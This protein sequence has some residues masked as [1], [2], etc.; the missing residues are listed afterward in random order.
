M[1]RRYTLLALLTLLPC[2]AQRY[3]FKSYGE[4]QGLTNLA[5]QCF[6]QD[7]TGFI[8]VGTQNGLFRYDGSQFEPFGTREGLPSN[9][10]ESLHESPD[11]DLWIGT[12]AGLARRRNGRFERIAIIGAQGVYGRN[13]IASDGSGRLFIATE[14][15]LAS[16]QAAVD[17]HEPFRLIPSAG[18]PVS[19]VFVNRDG[20]VW[21]AWG[22][23]IFRFLNGTAS[24]F[25]SP[26][27]PDE[28]WDAILADG[29]GDLWVR[30][31]K[32]LAV[33]RKGSQRFSL[34]RS[35][36]LNGNGTYGTLSLDPEGRLLVPSYLGLVRQNGAGW[37]VIGAKQGLTIDEI[38]FAKFDRE[39]SIWIGMLG[40][41]LLRWLGYAQWES[42]GHSEGLRRDSTWSIARDGAGT[43]WVGTQLGLNYST[44][45]RITDAPGVSRWAYLPQFDS[46]LVRASARTR[47]GD[48]WIGGDPGPLCRIEQASKMARCYGAPSGVTTT[49]I[50]HLMVDRDN[51]VWLSSRDGLYVSVPI[52]GPLWR[53]GG[54]RFGRI[55]IPGTEGEEGFFASVQD[56]KG[57]IWAGS[58]R[59]LVRLSGGVWSR[60]T[61]KDGLLQ[62]A[63]GYLASAGAGV[64][65]GYRESLGIT[66]VTPDRGRIALAH[67]SK[68]NGLE[69]DKAIFLGDDKHGRIWYGSDRGVDVLDNGSWR[70][71]GKADG[72]IW[73]D[74]NS[75]AFFADDD[76][77]VWIGTS[78]GLSHYRPSQAHF[79]DTPPPIVLTSARLGGKDVDV[80]RR[81]VA[82]HRDNAFSVTFAAPAYQHETELK[83]RYRLIGVEEEWTETTHREQRYAGLHPGVY[84]FEVAARDG[85][86]WSK[87][88]AR[89]TFEIKPPWWL[90]WWTRLL[91]F[92]IALALAWVMWKR[93]MVRLLEERR[94]LE[95][96]VRERT[97]EL[98]QERARVLEEKM[99]AE[100]EKVTVEQQ[101]REI[102]RLL[103]EAQQASRLKSEFLANMSHEIRTPMNGILGMTELVL[104]T[105]LTEEQRDYLE[106]AK[107]SADSLLALLNDILDLSKI[108]ADRLDLEQLGFS[109]R[110]CLAETVKTLE[111][112]ARERNLSLTWELASDVPTYVVGDPV[113]IRQILLNL[114]GN[115]IKF[116]HEGRISAR[117][118]LE[119]QLESTVRLHFAV[120]DTGIG[121]PAE[122]QELI[123]HAFRQA[124]GSTTRKYGGTGL[125][126]AICSKLVKL[127]GGSIWVQS[128]VGK[129]SEFHFTVA[130]QRTAQPT[131]SDLQQMMSAVQKG[132]SG[133]RRRLSILIA[134]DNAINQRLAMR[135]LQRRGHNVVVA[136]NGR[137]AL[138]ILEVADFDLVLMDVQMPEMD[139]LETTAEIRKREKMKGRYTPII[140]M[141]A[142]AMKGDREKCFAAGMDGYV[143]KPIEP[144]KMIAAVEN[145]LGSSLPADSRR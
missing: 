36:L 126:L 11:G 119:S 54:K 3:N 34:V 120:S 42:W 109:I 128:E 66:K 18:D 116:T 98:L 94:R 38:A 15:G 10:I 124:D 80:A 44:A 117:V 51:R 65:I 1:L 47:D 60:Y 86:E 111:L 31:Q 57:D 83:F 55:T 58:T 121:I 102:E 87:Q 43:L 41:G 99:R 84:T 76:G 129:G 74:V 9:R 71:L 13:G 101:N 141:T 110:Q 7:R 142:Y 77:S 95:S 112:K 93:R 52:D 30:S 37:E 73:D 33:W 90:T 88:P 81:T 136:D 70:H 107:S 20:T 50:L 118:T 135:L 17:R 22:S 61:A 5:V 131:I 67:Y 2:V 12:R 68:R 113:R 100:Q 140:A 104:A 115:A 139:G 46:I 144:E 24:Y 64:W 69:S 26:S 105:D 97:H 82:P 72:L 145:A 27:G 103:E 39:N 89:F 8:W 4:E 6:A 143:N 133:P 19:S 108:E 92:A 134:E 40:S 62:N 85:G 79:T 21:F 138:A 59:G 16:R 96:A 130:L 75:N 32:S 123:F 132:D 127:M 23:R 53:A 122:K 78:R 125:G 48:V 91:C 25:D 29:N 49:R 56:S 14:R 28:R 35:P 114:M 45:S 63:V 137:K 106:T